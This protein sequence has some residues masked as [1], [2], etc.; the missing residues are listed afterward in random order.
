MFS[1]WFPLAYD[2]LRAEARRRDIRGRPS[3][4]KAKLKRELGR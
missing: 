2:R 1:R 4:N 3:T